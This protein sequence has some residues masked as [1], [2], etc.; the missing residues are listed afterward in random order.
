MEVAGTSRTFT[1][2]YAAQNAGH[3]QEIFLKRLG[4][5]GVRQIKQVGFSW[6]ILRLMVTLHSGLSNWVL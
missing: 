2:H 6:P 1:S 4:L 5:K 3:F